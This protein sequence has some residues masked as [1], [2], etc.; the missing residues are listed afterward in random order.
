MSN[1]SIGNVELNRPDLSIANRIKAIFEQDS[2]VIVE[3]VPGEDDVNSKVVISVNSSAKAASLRKI[4]PETYDVSIPLDVEI[5]DISSIN[6]EDIV[7]KSEGNQLFS[8]T[9]VTDAVKGILYT[10]FYGENGEAYNVS[11]EKFDITLRDLAQEIA[12][13]VGTKVIFDLPSEAERKGYST[14]TKAIMDGSKI[15]EL[16]FK[17]ESDFKTRLGETIEVLRNIK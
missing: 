3:Y 8:Y 10:L 5:K 2:N 1:V 16:G 12:E 6:G 11:D 17:V 13:I 4:L 14:A 9:Y 15:K 7:L